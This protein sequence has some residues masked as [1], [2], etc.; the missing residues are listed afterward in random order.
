MNSLFEKY[1]DAPLN[2]LD[3]EIFFRDGFYFMTLLLAF[4]VVMGG[5]YQTL[6]GLLGDGGYLAWVTEMESFPMMRSLLASMLTILISLL[7]VIAA[8]AI[9]V[10]RARD[11]RGRPYSSLIGFTSREMIPHTIKAYGEIVA[12]FP[13][14]MGLFGLVGAV[15][16]TNPYIPLRRGMVQALEPLSMSGM[17][18]RLGRGSAGIEEMSDYLEAVLASGLGGLLTSILLSFAVLVLCYG[19]LQVYRYFLVLVT[20][21]IGYMPRFAIPLWVQKSERSRD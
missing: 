1:I 5:F 3:R 15:C 17:V 11:M 6:D 21:L 20:N 14:A 16:A 10:K 18:S 9:L 13:F 2:A 19:F 4:G 7:V 8:A 12:L